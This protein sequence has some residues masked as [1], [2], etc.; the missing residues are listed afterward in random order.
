MLTQADLSLNIRCLHLI[1]TLGIFPFRIDPRTAKISSRSGSSLGFWWCLIFA[2]QFQTLWIAWRVRLKYQT[3]PGNAFLTL[4]LDYMTFVPGQMTVWMAFMNF[5][6]WPEATAGIFNSFMATSARIA[7]KGQR[8]WSRLTFLEMI[9][10]IMPG[11]AFPTA[12][13]V[14]VS[15]EILSTWPATAGWHVFVRIGLTAMD[16]GTLVCRTSWV[17]F[18]LLIQLLFIGE[19]SHY[20]K[21][22]TARLR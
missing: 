3:N 15:F 11:F 17:Y 1:S 9:T 5:K 18:S 12:A 16:S 19:L 8:F 20:L 10:A 2:A 13:L 6:R 4:P 21:K 22:E 7:P 14:I